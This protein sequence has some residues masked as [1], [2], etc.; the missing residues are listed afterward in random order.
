M[1]RNHALQGVRV[2]DFSHIVAGPTCTRVLADFGAEVIRIEFEQ[3]LDYS[4]HIPPVL[5]GSSPNRS[6]LFNN[7]N[8]NK[9]SATLNAM[10]PSGMELLH[11]LISVSDVVAENFSSR[12]LDRWDL[13]YEAQRKIRPDVIY[14]SLSGFGHSGPDRDYTTWGPTAQA[15]SGL[16][17]M[18]GL[19]G[20]EPAGWGFSYMDHTAGYYGAIACLMAVHHRNRTGEGQWIDLSQ[21]EGG[22]AMTGTSILDY[23]VNQRPFRRPGNPPGN[24]STQP[25]VAPHNTYR[26]K[27]EDRWCVISVFNEEQWD[28]LVK[29]IGGPE[30]T[31]ED[32][33][34]SNESRVVNQDELDRAIESWTCQRSPHEVMATLQAVGVPAGAVQ[35]ARDKVEDDPQLRARNFLPEVD[36][37]EIGRNKVE[38]IPVKLSHSPW[39]LRMASPV[40]GEHSDYVYRQVLGLTENEIVDLREEGAI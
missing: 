28:S 22:I 20:H 3:T 5:P 7:I 33:F 35:N 4:R 29:A 34:C 31:K 9:L 2:V 12:V 38:A 15:L 25:A 30:W 8:R 21:V 16:T 39:K 37:P 18:S 40:L 32:R 11:R 17:F 36:H 26:C 10:H 1:E 23:T 13:D 19:P 14:I 24:R 27:G 6:G